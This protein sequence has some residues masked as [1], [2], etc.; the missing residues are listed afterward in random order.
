M[1]FD[2]VYKIS[3]NYMKKI[4]EAEHPYR[5]SPN[6]YPMGSRKYSSRHFRK[7]DDGTFSVWYANRERMDRIVA[8]EDVP[9]AGAWLDNRKLVVIHPD[10]SVEFMRDSYDQGDNMY[11]TEALGWHL[12]NVKPKGGGVMTSNGRGAS[13]VQHP[14]FKGL[15]VNLETGDAVTPYTLERRVLNKQRAKRLMEGYAD[16]LITYRPMVKSMDT[17]GIHG[18]LT[19]LYDELGMN[20][21]KDS[22]RDDVVTLINARRYVDAAVLFSFIFGNAHWRY[23]FL[24]KKG[25]GVPDDY[26]NFISIIEDLDKVMETKFKDQMY[27]GNPSVF[28]T[29]QVSELQTCKW[30][31]LIK[32]NGEVVKSTV[33]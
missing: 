32:V 18:V 31:V 27:M 22:N 2:D 20:G 8:G 16:F 33:K 28:D 15:R 19:D 23:L 25:K 9:H 5:G 7:E 12:C 29:E 17:V 6:A 30:G 3:Y 13:M 11:L 26:Y 1:A 10:N 21:M 24:A 4:T 14:L